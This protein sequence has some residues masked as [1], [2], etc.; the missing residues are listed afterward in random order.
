[1]NI[2][3]CDKCL[4][5]D[6]THGGVK[7]ACEIAKKEIFKEIYT[8]DIYSTLKKE[9]LNLLNL[10]NIKN[11][12]NLENLKGN[13]LIV[14]PIHLPL[15]N[16][17]IKSKINCKTNNYKFLNHHQIVALLLDDFKEKNILKIEVTGVKGKTSSVFMLNEIF[18]CKN[19]LLLSSLGAYLFK[20]D[21]EFLLKKNI[22]IT[23][24][25]ILETITLADKITNPKCE[26]VP[27]KKVEEA[28]EVA[29]FE[30]SLGVSGIGDVGLLTNIVENYKIAK[31]KKD[32]AEAK[33]QIFNCKLVAIEKETLEKYYP[34]ESKNKI[35]SFS[36]NDK[37]ANLFLKNVKYGFNKTKIE[38][39]YFNLKTIDNK[40][41][42]GSIELSTFAL[43]EHHLQNV[44]GVITCALSLNVNPNMIVNGL[45]NFKGIKGRTSIKKLKDSY[46]IEEVNPGL[47]VESIKKSIEMLDKFKDCSII[48]GGKYGVTCEEIDEKK[49]AIYLDD[50]IKNSEYD[51]ILTDELGKGILDKMN[52]KLDFI[53]NASDAIN[54]VLDRKKN[55]L[56]IYR[57]N[58]SELSKR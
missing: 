25:S 48:I 2:D 17:E 46:I 18:K 58:Y 24:A 53:S 22:S 15:T 12:P 34:N 45:S 11:I 6:L 55:I 19:T 13:L 40:E 35:N 14:S 3:A 51:I 16:E 4:I 36:L 57:S 31:N 5:I 20:D 41:I 30:S 9:D 43:G 38:I 32:A 21:K 39:E 27:Q 44:L 23:P 52:K 1:M 29:I 28:Y 10:Y 8:Y 37:N 26:I 42:S 50:L 47:N 56:F 49:L 7:I 33:S 54:T